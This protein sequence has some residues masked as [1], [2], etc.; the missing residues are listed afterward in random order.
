MPATGFAACH[1]NQEGKRG[2]RDCN[3][4]AALEMSGGPITVL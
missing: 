2:V 4:E 3:W 1:G